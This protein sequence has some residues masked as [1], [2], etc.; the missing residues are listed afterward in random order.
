M[1]GA[2][3]ATLRFIEEPAPQPGETVPVAPGVHWLRM[4]LPMKLDHIN[5]WLL[6]DQGG[7]VLVDTGMGTQATR[8]A[9]LA[10]ERGLF[11]QHPLRLIVLTHLH[12]DHVGLAAWLQQ[13]FGVPVWTSHDTHEQLR[14]LTREPT[15]AELAQRIAQLVHY[16]LPRTTAD[17]L[18]P[19]LRFDTYRTDVSGLPQIERFAAG[20][21]ISR[22]ADRDWHWLATGG[23]AFGHLCL[24]SSAPQDILIAGDQVLPSMT[25]NV[26]LNTMVA[27]PDPLG[28]YLNDLERL[29]AIDRDT[30]VLPSHGQPFRGLSLRA[31]E[32]RQHHEQ[33]LAKVLAACTRPLTAVETLPFLYRREHQGFQLYLALGE[34]LAHLEYLA[35]HGRM[36]C[37]EDG[38]I[39]RYLTI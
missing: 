21:E 23:H 29:T 37:S 35:A 22:W 38:G 5:L 12:P 36:E 4:P 11:R 26:S 3:A 27:D 25:S 18:A 20:G 9:W 30:L 2:S 10:L 1:T 7:C 14:T 6:E 19:M 31:R 13:R 39:R 17:Q 28:T 34:A 16:G 8:D 33:R 15:P 24:H 32:L